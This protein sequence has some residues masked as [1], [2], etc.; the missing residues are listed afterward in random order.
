MNIPI[1]HWRYSLG[2]IDW[3]GIVHFKK[4]KGKNF[5]NQKLRI[6]DISKFHNIEETGL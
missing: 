3:T 5:S 2:I 6:L 4:V 1:G